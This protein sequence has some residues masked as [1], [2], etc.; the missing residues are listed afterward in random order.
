MATITSELAW[1]DVEGLATELATKL[2]VV[3]GVAEFDRVV[4]VARGGLI[5]AALV[6]GALGV[7]RVETVQV[8]LYD[9][10]AKAPVPRM[11][12]AAPPATGPSGAPERTLVI[13]EMVDSGATLRFLQGLYPQ[14]SYAVLVARIG[15]ERPQAEEGLARIGDA[16]SAHGVWAA[17][18]LATERW[19]LFPWS[20]A[21]DRAVSGSDGA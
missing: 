8:A 4:A 16:E 20:P 5:P 13:D 1:H 19:I 6:A 17:A 14:A 3:S 15:D 12:G 21:E 10:S 11:L 18:T 9:G 2:P 7:K